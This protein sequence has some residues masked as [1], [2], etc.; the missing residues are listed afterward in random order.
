VR[1]AAA[2]ARSTDRNLGSN[3]STDRNL[4]S[5]RSTDRNLGS[6]RSTPATL[7]ETMRH[8]A[9]KF[10]IKAEEFR[11]LAAFSASGAAIVRRLAAENRP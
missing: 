3:R 1:T 11:S 7:A 8:D 9:A 6:N 4:G 2:E 5:N 10:S